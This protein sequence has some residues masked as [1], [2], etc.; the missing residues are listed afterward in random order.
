LRFFCQSAPSHFV[1]NISAINCKNLPFSQSRRA[2]FD[3]GD[4]DGPNRPAECQVV[5]YTGV[6]DPHPAPWDELWREK[7]R[8]RFFCGGSALFYTA[9]KPEKSRKDGIFTA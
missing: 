6:K 5:D 2:H 7:P 8:R 4:L 9:E 1:A 3:C